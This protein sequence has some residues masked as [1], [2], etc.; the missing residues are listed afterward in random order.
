MI[1]N[2]ISALLAFFFLVSISFFGACEYEFVVPE[3][4]IIPDVISFSEDIIPI[5]DNSCN[6]SGCHVS[7]FGI[8]DLSPAN[9]YNDLFLKNMI[10]V[11]VPVQSDLYQKLTEASGTHAGRSTP[12]EQALILEWINKG[13]K[14]N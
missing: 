1:K 11:D 3:K 13:A 4:V 6:F 8:L 12:T 7:G 2:R 14:N 10:D 9:A 5:F